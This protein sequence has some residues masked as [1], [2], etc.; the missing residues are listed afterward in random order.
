MLDQGRACDRSFA[1]ALAL[2]ENPSG[3]I[4]RVSLSAPPASDIC[5]HTSSL[6]LS[7]FAALLADRRAF[8]A[9]VAPGRH[10]AIDWNR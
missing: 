4:G 5:H 8:D 3:A 2:S 7:A 10:L 1:F 6:S 9:V